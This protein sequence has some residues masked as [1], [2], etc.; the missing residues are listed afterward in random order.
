MRFCFSVAFLPRFRELSV[1]MWLVP[2]VVQGLEKQQVD[3][4]K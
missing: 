2:L 4:L 3:T 1:D